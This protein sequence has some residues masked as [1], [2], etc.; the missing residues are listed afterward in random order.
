M[1]LMI[2]VVALLMVLCVFVCARACEC[3]LAVFLSD[4]CQL[5]IYLMDAFYG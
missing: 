2:S 3:V 4:L 5:Y 1:L